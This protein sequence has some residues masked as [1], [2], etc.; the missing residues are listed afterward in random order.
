CTGEQVETARRAGLQIQTSLSTIAYY[1]FPQG[2]WE[3][4]NT[5]LRDRRVRL[6][7]QYAVNREALATT[8][9]RGAAQPAA[10]V[11][12][13][14]TP[15][16]D[17]AIPVF[18]YNPAEARR[19]LAEAGYP[20]GFRLPGGL[21][22][23]TAFTLQDVVVAL[24]A[25]W[26]AI[27]VEFDVIANERAVFVDK[28]FGRNN[29]PKGDIWLARQ[30]DP[31]GFGGSRTFIGCGRPLGAPPAA[32]LWCNPEWDRLMDL[33][34]AERDLNRRTDLLRQA[35][36]IK[37]ADAVYQAIYHEPLFT[38]NTERIRNVTLEHPLY[39]RFDSAFRVR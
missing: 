13:L 36:R 5:P 3:L 31:I 29:L 23:T 32:L 17:P 34:Y 20:N 1:A 30:S 33:A 26:R 7:M 28:A 21:D 11:A 18:P 4:R 35:V 37:V 22:Y 39:F 6:A 25:D 10:A 15:Y 38:L 12:V 19:L 2:S 16:N 14:G 9:F 27:G 24:Q 8:L